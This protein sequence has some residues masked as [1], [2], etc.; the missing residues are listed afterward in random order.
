MLS[1]EVKAATFDH[2][3]QI[4]LWFETVYPDPDN[5]NTHTHLGLHFGEISRMLDVLKDAGKDFGSREQLTLAVDVSRY[6][7]RRFK[8]GAEGITLALSDLDR[9]ALLD[10]ICAQIVSAIGLAHMMGMDISGAL[11]EVSESNTSRF[12]E[13][14]QPIFNEQHSV[15][16]GPYYRAPELAAYT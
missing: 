16:K 2:I 3:A 7:E 6:T 10:A 4:K 15:I 12:D 14:G 8:A 11:Q 5:R 9:V 13:E 1:Q